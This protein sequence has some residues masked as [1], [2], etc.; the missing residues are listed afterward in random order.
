MWIT[1]SRILAVPVVLYLIYLGNQTTDMWA[2]LI[3]LVAA[4]TDFFDGYTARLFNAETNL[5]KFMD[6]IADKILVTGTLVVLTYF[7]KVDPLMVILIMSRDTLIGGV[8][9]VAAAEGIV[10][11][12]KQ[13]GKVKTAIQ[14]VAIPVVIYGGTYGEIYYLAG[15]YTLWLTVALSLYSGFDYYIGYLRARK[16]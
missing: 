12:A 2:A 10:I 4:T 1:W 7:Q 15:Y 11:A 5:G 14:M 16:K 13:T 8:R 9:A 3:F 6:P